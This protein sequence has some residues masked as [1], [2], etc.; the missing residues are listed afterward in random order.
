[1]I[2]LRKRFSNLIYAQGLSAITPLLALALNLMLPQAAL[3][4]S[5]TWTATSPLATGRE[6]HTATL[7]R[8]SK[9]LAAGGWVSSAELYNS[10]GLCPAIFELLLLK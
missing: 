9:V 8:N 1:M 5:F 7:L 10:A 2:A 3:A 4:A 6:T